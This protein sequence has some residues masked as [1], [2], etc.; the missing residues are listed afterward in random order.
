MSFRCLDATDTEEYLTTMPGYEF[1]AIQTAKVIN[2]VTT[3]YVRKVVEMWGPE[4]QS[5]M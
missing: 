1:S 4:S 2:E 3:E 5:V